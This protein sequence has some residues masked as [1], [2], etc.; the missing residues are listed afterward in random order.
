MT[1]NLHIFALQCYKAYLH[2]WCFSSI[3][4]HHY[5]ICTDGGCHLHL[6]LLVFFNCQLAHLHTFHKQ[7]WAHITTCTN[8]VVVVAVMVVHVHI[9]VCVCASLCVCMC[10]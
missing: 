7:L 6:A 4:W 8:V 2:W 3:N 10:V 5:Y 9:H 1:E